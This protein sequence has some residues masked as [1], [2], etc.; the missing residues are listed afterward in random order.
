MKWCIPYITEI[1]T[2]IFNKC[3]EE[4]VYPDILKIARV[5]ALPKSGD[6]S[7]A[8]NFRPIS[9]LPQINKVFEKLIHQRLL[10]FLKKFRIL[11]PQQFGFLKK[12]STSH[13]VTCLYEKL[14]QNLENK[15][16]T[17][18][19]FVDLKAAFDTVDNTILLDKLEHYV[20]RNK[21][22]KLLTSYLH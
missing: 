14:I 6:D 5:T 8:D 9:I 16:D 22:L 3:V 2:K 20:I 13:S 21:T 11:S 18:V 7:D 15:L 12:H 19:L 17:A 10:S 1:L 4:G